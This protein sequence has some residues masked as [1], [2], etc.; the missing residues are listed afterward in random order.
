M[1]THLPD[2]RGVAKR[3]AD[4]TGYFTPCGVLPGATTVLGKTSDGKERLE[5]WLKRPDAQSI[6][7]AAKARGT[8]THNCIEAWI[9]AHASG[10]A[11]PRFNHFSFGTYWRSA[12]SWLRDH[13][14]QAVALEKPV[15][16]PAGYAGSF[17]A[18]GYAAYGNEPEALTLFDWKTSKRQRDESLVR[19]YYDQL[20]AYSHAI[21][22]VYGIR[23]DRG[24]L[25]IARP[26]QPPDVWELSRQELTEATDRFLRRLEA[27]YAMPRP[28]EALDS[29][30]TQSNGKKA[31]QGPEEGGDSDARVQDWQAPQR[32]REGPRR[33]KP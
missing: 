28:E 23:P 6:S 3:K 25:M 9:I 31:D 21:E 24:V 29:T 4:K 19:D 20:G 18:L 30:A 2:P 1:L 27:F 8:W 22:Y 32:K 7:D 5:Q 16:H 10:A 15:Y 12:Q 13:W 26:V 11:E 17:D 33:F 14:T